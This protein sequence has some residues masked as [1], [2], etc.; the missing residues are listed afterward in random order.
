M[1]WRR[2]TSVDHG[3]DWGAPSHWPRVSSRTRWRG[4]SADVLPLG[5]LHRVAA[6]ACVLLALLTGCTAAGTSSRAGSRLAT[7]APSVSPSV[8][9][10]SPTAEPGVVTNVFVFVFVVENHSFAQTKAQMPCTFGP[11]TRFGYATATRQF[12]T[13][14]CRTVVRSS[15]AVRGHG[16]QCPVGKCDQFQPIGIRAGHCLGHGGGA[17]HRRQAGQLCS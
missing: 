17:L 4:L 3:D 9:G 11:V 8:P 12:G 14:R 6:R 7:P 13:R 5:M 1:L 16:R 10:S 2:P 15:V